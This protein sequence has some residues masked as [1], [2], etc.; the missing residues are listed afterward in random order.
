MGLNINTFDKD[1]NRIL[2][3]ERLGNYHTLHILRQWVMIHVEGNSKELVDS[4]YGLDKDELAWA[5]LKIKKC[6][7]L[8]DHSD[9]DGGYKSFTFY[10]D[11]DWN[12]WEWQD[13]DALRLELK[14]LKKNYYKSMDEDTKIVFDRFNGIVNKKSEDGKM[15]V[16]IEFT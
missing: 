5:K 11:A 13:L 8:I 6:P 7:K 3:Y 15:A 4:C 10:K 1:D 16:K 9:C 12:S 14:M 2:D